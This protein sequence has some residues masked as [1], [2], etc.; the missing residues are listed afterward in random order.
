MNVLGQE[1]RPTEGGLWKL[2][3]GHPYSPEGRIVILVLE[4]R[5]ANFVRRICQHEAYKRQRVISLQPPLCPP[6]RLRR[7]SLP[8][9]T[10]MRSARS[11]S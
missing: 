7:R 8:H 2:S 4:P 6:L 5:D 3:G 1:E 11:V 10:A 9:S